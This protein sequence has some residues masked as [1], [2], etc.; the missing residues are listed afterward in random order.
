MMVRRLERW[1]LL[2]EVRSSAE[3]VLDGYLVAVNVVSTVFYLQDY[4][5]DGVV[6]VV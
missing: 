6:F 3:V 4:G 1:C 5:V 2:D